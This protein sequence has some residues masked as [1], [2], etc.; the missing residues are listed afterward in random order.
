MAL[1]HLALDYNVALAIY[2]HNAK[3]KIGLRRPVFTPSSP[4]DKKHLDPKGAS[5]SHGDLTGNR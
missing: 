5:K 1:R 4:R 3:N 2:H